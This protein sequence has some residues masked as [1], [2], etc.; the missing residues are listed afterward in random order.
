MTFDALIP[1][2]SLPIESLT[3][4]ECDW[5]ASIEAA[6]HV[7]SFSNLI[8]LDVDSRHNDLTKFFCTITIDEAGMPYL[9]R[10]QYLSI[11]SRAF[12]GDDLDTAIISFLKTHPCI[13]YLE[14]KF[15]F[16]SGIIFDAIICHLPDLETFLVRKSISLPAESVRKIVDHC[17]KLLYIQ[18]DR[19][20]RTELYFPEGYRR[21][22]H[23][24]LTLGCNALKHLRANPYADRI[25]D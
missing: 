10:L 7:R 13:R 21:D 19:I 4:H 6:L 16:I 24:R 15:D 2:I 9:P 5:I 8:K 11:G 23:H 22:R 18:I 25:N 3:I 1:F 14:L 20:Q 17:P 12:Q